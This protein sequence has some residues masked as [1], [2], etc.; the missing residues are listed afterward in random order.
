MRLLKKLGIEPKEILTLNEH[1][2]SEQLDQ[3]L[4]KIANGASLA[5]VSDCGTPLFS[6][7][8]AQLVKVISDAGFR[9]VPV[10]GVS[11][12]MA[13]LSV[14]PAQLKKFYFA[15]FLPRA[16]RERNAEL[17]RLNLLRVPVILM[18]TPYRMAAILKAVGATFGKNRLATLAMNLTQPDETIL[19]GTVASIHAKVQ[20]RKAEFIHG[21]VGVV[22][23]AGIGGLGPQA[24]Q[25]D[26]V[27]CQLGAQDLGGHGPP[28]AQIGGAP[29]LAYSLLKRRKS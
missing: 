23:A 11:S 15:G 27:A 18:D 20:N 9:V 1:N 22:Q 8:G 13:A 12:L 10:P 24:R 26:F 16:D 29:H 7:P 19:T 14:T 5:L 25:E 3:C 17:K 6:D 21:Q 4:L 2:E 28:R